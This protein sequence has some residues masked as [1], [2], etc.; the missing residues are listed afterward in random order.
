MAPF[1]G[2]GAGVTQLIALLN[3]LLVQVGSINQTIGKVFPQTIGTAT[4]ATGGA[5]TLPANPVGFLTVVNP[6]TGATVK[7]PYYG[8]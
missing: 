6:A 4:T 2:I 8:P 7:I 1:D 5:A 3:N